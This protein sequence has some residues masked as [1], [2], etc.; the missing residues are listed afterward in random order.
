MQVRRS[1]ARKHESSPSL[2]GVRST[3]FQ[4]PRPRC[5]LSCNVKRGARLPLLRRECSRP[6]TRFYCLHTVAIP[7][8]SQSASLIPRARDTGSTCARL[9]PRVGGEHGEARQHLH[10]ELP[11]LR[12]DDGQHREGG[13]AQPARGHPQRD[14]AV[15][16]VEIEQVV[17]EVDF[18]RDERRERERKRGPIGA[19]PVLHRLNRADVRLGRVGAKGVDHLQQLALLG[20]RHLDQQQQPRQPKVAQKAICELAVHRHQAHADLA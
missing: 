12:A 10:D 2:R 3:D 17:R 9:A 15:V 8:P 18:E 13:G 14:D 20:R 16:D 7:A 19:E 6:G 11:V 4:W 5:G 1:A